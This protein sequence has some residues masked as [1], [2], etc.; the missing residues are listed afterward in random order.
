VSGHEESADVAVVT[1][2]TLQP[3]GTS[4]VRRWHMRGCCARTLADQLG[5]P[6]NEA[7]LTAEAATALREHTVSVPGIVI[8]QREAR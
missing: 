8:T 2:G 5:E 4:I 6:N 7:L 3:D 1:I